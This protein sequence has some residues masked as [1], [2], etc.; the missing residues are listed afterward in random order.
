MLTSQ[1]KVFR[2]FWHATVPLSS[3][4]GETP[5]PFTLLGENIVLFLD[6]NG[7]ARGAEGPLLPP[8]RQAQQGPLRRRPAANAATTA[9]PTTAAARWCA[10]RSTTRAARSR[11]TT[12]RRPTAAWR[13]YGYAWVAL[14]EPIAPIPDMPEFDDAGLAHHLPVLRTLGHQPAARAGEQ[15]RQQPLQLRAPRHLRRGRPAQAEQ[16]RTGR[17]GHRLLCR[18]HHRTPPTRWSTSVSPA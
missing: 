5:Q 6:E 16:V 4:Q 15:L 7:P 3:L 18:D 8:H 1:Q 12:A 13:K 2:K 10:S 14:E 11:P 17:A 9:G